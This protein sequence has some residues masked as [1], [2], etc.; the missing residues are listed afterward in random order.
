V[1]KLP[2]LDDLMGGEIAL[3]IMLTGFSMHQRSIGAAIS[4][5]TKSNASACSRCLR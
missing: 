3:L 1:A 2:R 5:R 4:K